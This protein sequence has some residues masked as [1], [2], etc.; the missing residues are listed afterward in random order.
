[1]L[2][3]NEKW[4]LC[5]I[6]ESHHFGLWPSFISDLAKRAFSIPAEPLEKVLGEVLEKHFGKINVEPT[7]KALRL[8]SEAISHYT[9][10]DADQYGAFRVGPSYP[11]CLDKDVKPIAAPYAMFGNRILNARYTAWDFGR[12]SLSSIRIHEEIKSLATMLEL[13]KKGVDILE[14]IQD[15]DKN[16]P[17]MYLINLGKFICSCTQTGINVKKWYL[18]ITKLKA[19]SNRDKIRELI[20]EIERLG[21]EEIKNAESA[22]PLVESDSRLG[23]EPSMEYMT[24]AEHIRWKIRQVKYVLESELA[25]YKKGVEK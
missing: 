18:L 9:P 7:D 10:T 1:M 21:N 4:G 12:C 8:W 11:L 20:N 14:N 6:M 25:I 19:E 5:G 17:L 3:A 16:D 2:E 13:M 22:I 15:K 24:D 23:W